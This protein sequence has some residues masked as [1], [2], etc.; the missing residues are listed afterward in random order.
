M[1]MEL[2]IWITNTREDQIF[3]RKSRVYCFYVKQEE[4]TMPLGRA[5]EEE[6]EGRPLQNLKLSLTA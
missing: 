1:E 6:G 4:H 5:Y 2:S 3:R